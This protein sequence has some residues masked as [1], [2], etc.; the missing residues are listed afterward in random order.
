MRRLEDFADADLRVFD[1]PPLPPPEAIRDVY[2]IG[3]CGKGMGAL[4]ELLAEAGF[5]QVDVYWE[6]TDEETGEGSGE[7][8]PTLEGEADPAWVAYIVAQK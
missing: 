6:G 3:I 2:L 4:A 1:R 5:S 7:Y 8:Y